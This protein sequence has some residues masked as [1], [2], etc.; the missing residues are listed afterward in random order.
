MNRIIFAAAALAASAA[1][2]YAQ[3]PIVGNWK[4]ELGDTAAIA[5][6]GSG[7]CITLKSG[8]HAGE[9]IGNFNGKDG[10]YEG[11]I[12]D[13]DAKKTYDGSLTVSGDALKMKGC[14]LK[15]VCESQTWPRL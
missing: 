14:V 2:A 4:T 5:P 6:C 13:P 12:T 15:V 7:Y 3:D 1:I 11:K 8:K 10:S 9:Q